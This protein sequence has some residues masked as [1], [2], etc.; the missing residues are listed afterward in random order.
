MVRF[1]LCS[2]AF[3]GWA[4][5]EL[6]GGGDF[7]PP[8][9]REVAVIKEELLPIIDNKVIAVDITKS[10]QTPSTDPVAPV[11]VTLASVSTDSAL[12][13]PTIEFNP[14]AGQ[15]ITT[16]AGSEAAPVI[17]EDPADIRYVSGNRVN[18]RNGPGTNYQVL[19]QLQRGSETEVLQSPGDGWVK[20]RVA[21]SGRI[22]WMAER[23]LTTTN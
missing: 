6:S 13:A 4:F 21:G 1:M 23:L 2:F 7:E 9:P 15:S 19:V 5:Y 17:E 12:D 11:K 10:L 14:A 22:G 18:M 20:I 16:D 3:M 8:A